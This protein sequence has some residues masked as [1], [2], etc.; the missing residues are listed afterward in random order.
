MN[1]TVGELKNWLINNSI[2]LLNKN[3]AKLFKGCFSRNQIVSK[4][5]QQ[6]FI[7]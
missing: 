7:F 4:N 2:K 5:A 3:I 6:F 1:S